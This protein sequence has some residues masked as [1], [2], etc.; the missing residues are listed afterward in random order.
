MPVERKGVGVSAGHPVFR[1]LPE[2]SRHARARKLLAQRK[3]TL[4]IHECP[5]ASG[6]S[7]SP[8]AARVAVLAVVA[9][10]ARLFDQLLRRIGQ[11]GCRPAC[12]DTRDELLD[13]Q[14]LVGRRSRIGIGMQI[15]RL[16]P[17]FDDA[18]SRGLAGR[19]RQ[20]QRPGR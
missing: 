16:A 12:L 13:R 19:P 1:K 4:W 2:E 5:S 10:A 17:S 6:R 7:A 3:V 14:L 18:P 8:R 20:A 15:L 11:I 9:P